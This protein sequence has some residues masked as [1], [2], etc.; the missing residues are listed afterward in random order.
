MAGSSRMR[1]AGSP[2]PLSTDGS[3]AFARFSMQ[4][5]VPKILQEVVDRN[6]D[7]PPEIKGAVSKLA[8]DI[9]S[10]EHMPALAFPAPDEAE[11]QPVRSDETWL[12]T[13]W[14]FAECYVYR[15]LM[16]AVRYFEKGRD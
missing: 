13:E 9:A 6:P 14:F 1:N 10:N 4:V 12:S 5:R 3:N 8:Q 16:S 11:W 15:C 7:Y 2:A